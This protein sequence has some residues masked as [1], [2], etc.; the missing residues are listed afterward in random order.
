M[1]RFILKKSYF[2]APDSGGNKAYGLLREGLVQSGKI[3]VAK[4]IIRSKEQLAIVRV[5]ENGLMMETIHFPDEVRKMKMFQM[6]LK[7]KRS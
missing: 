4:I 1:I 2:L 5:Y 3:G 7:S 6:Y